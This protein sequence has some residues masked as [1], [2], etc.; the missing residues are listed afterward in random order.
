MGWLL[1]NEYGM[2]MGLLGLVIGLLMK[3]VG[4]FI[5]DYAYGTTNGMNGIVNG[6]MFF[7]F[8]EKMW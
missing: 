5:W 1:T 4:L 3:L 2:N 7:F 8:F 6:I